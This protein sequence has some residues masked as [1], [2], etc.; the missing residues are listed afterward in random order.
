MAAWM[1]VN[2]E[3]IYGTRP[4]KIFGEGPTVAAS[5]SF[6]ENTA[7]TP[8]DIRFTTKGGNLYAI[9][10]GWPADGKVVVTSLAK[11]DD[12]NVNQIERVELLGG[13]GELQFTQTA[14]GLTV[15]LPAQ[16]TSDV[17]CSLKIT[18]SNLQPVKLS[19]PQSRQ[20]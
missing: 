5:G 15:E 13:K 6:K 7:Y 14:A 9:A 2:G 19:T 3:A 16:K 18:G 20:L 17:A 10:L 4:W 11:T 8:Q 1:M 12:V